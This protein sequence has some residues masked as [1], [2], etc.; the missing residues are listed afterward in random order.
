MDPFVGTWRLVSFELRTSDGQVNYPYGKDA[1]GYV[2]YSHDG[3]VTFTVMSA[4]RPKFASADI[5]AGSSAEKAAAVDTYFSYCGTYKVR[6]DRVIH[7]LEV[8]LFPNWIGGD[9]ERIF[10]FKGNRLILRTPPL[11]WGGREQTGMVTWE[12]V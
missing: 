11:S 6:G 2:M 7:H 1:I 5:A 3:Y 9:Q 10:E 12:R 8:S 4:N